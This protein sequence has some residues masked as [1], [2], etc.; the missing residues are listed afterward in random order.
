VSNRCD[1]KLRCSGAGTDNELSGVVHFVKDAVGDGLAFGFAWEVLGIN[2]I[3]L[4]TVARTGVLEIAN[5]LSFF[6]STLI[7]GGLC[8]IN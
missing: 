2:F 8:R 7:T 3:G 4:A 6:A 5:K 1:C